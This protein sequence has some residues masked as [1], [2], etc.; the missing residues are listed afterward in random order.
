MVTPSKR[1]ATQRYFEE[2]YGVDTPEDLALWRDDIRASQLTLAEEQDL[3]ECVVTDITSSYERCAFTL[4]QA[5]TDLQRGD[6][7][8]AAVKLY[9][10]VFYALRAEILLANQVVIRAGRFLIVEASRGPK[11][12][13]YNGEAKGDHGVSIALARR[14]FSQTDILQTQSIDGMIPYEW[15]KVVRETVQYKLRRPPELENID[16]FFP[17]SH[18]SI[19]EQVKTFMADSDPYYCFD[20]D[21]AAL[22]LPLKRF[23]LTAK[24]LQAKSIHCGVDFYKLM[25]GFY[26]Q[27]NPCNL[28]K[29]FV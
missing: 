2:K 26:K 24:K 23:E 14:F 10:S 17:D 20:P 11:F 9:Y 27:G 16:P 3:V 28:L 19:F 25:D 21:Y 15:L 18:W 6:R 7:L 1:A 22:A 5:I 13:Q 4:F 29:P 12:S 8:W